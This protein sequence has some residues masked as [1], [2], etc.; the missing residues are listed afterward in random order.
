MGVKG[1]EA[2]CVR[3]PYSTN[4]KP[5]F[6]VAAA[7]AAAA[8]ALSAAWPAAAPGAGAACSLGR[9]WLGERGVGMGEGE[10][11]GGER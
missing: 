8:A 6:R 7:A 9:L 5:L 4:A 11:G 2:V 10:R 3:P 1:G